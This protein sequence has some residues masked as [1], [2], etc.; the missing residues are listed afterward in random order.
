MHAAR[1]AGGRR[2][3]PG[4]IVDHLHGG[5]SRVPTVASGP[6]H[7]TAF[8][9]HTQPGRRV[10]HRAG[11]FL[12]DAVLTCPVPQ[13]FP[14]ALFTSAPGRPG[15]RGHERTARRSTA[16]LE[17]AEIS[18]RGMTPVIVAY[19]VSAVHGAVSSVGRAAD[20]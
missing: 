12:R 2:N 1:G 5:A 8:G 4:R 9:R 19:A 3:R 14:V 6:H 20:S 11:T 17:D 13:A 16:I 15:G 7:R 10:Q 18:L